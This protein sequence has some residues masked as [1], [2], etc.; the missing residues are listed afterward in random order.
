MSII[1]YKCFNEDMTNR[2]GMK[3]SIGKIYIA[4]GTIKF[5]NNGN[6]FHIC[7]NIEDTFRYFDVKNKDFNICEVIGSGKTVK[8]DDEYYGYYDM[9]SVEQLEIIKKL[10]RKE[11]I[12][13]GLDLDFLRTKRFIQGIKLSGYELEL[14]KQ[15]F[16]E[17]KT[18]LDTIAYYQENDIDVY[19]KQRGGING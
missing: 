9:Y 16:I 11:I 7:T 15:K 4:K 8:Y 10:S 13:I 17:N 1:G 19:S 3:F 5:G 18:I 14:F 2:Y 6:G 12:D